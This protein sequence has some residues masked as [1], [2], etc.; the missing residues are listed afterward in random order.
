MFALAIILVGMIGI[1]AMIPFAGRQAAS[2]YNIAHGIAAGDNAVAVFNSHSI[3]SPTLNAPWQLVDDIYVSPAPPFNPTDTMGDSNLSV[4]E[5]FPKLYEGDRT[6]FRFYS[7]Y[8]YQYD[9]LEGVMPPDRNR[10]ALAQNRALGMGF[11][12]DPLF[13]GQHV[14]VPLPLNFGDPPRKLYDRDWNNLRRTRF[15]FYHESYP[16][17]MDPFASYSG[18]PL[19]NTPRLTRVSIR[20]P[21]TPL[22]TVNKGWLHLPAAIRMATSSGGDVSQISAE[23][24]RG[25]GPL[26]DFTLNQLRDANKIPMV[27]ESILQASSSLSQ[28]SWMATLT[29]S[30]STPV[31]NPLS[32]PGGVYTPPFLPPMPFYPE[33]YD[34]AVIVFAKRDVRELVIEKYSDYA[35]IGVAPSSERLARVMAFGPESRTSG[36]FDMMLN[37]DSKVNAKVRIGDWLMLSRYVYDDPTNLATTFPIRESHKWYRIISVSGEDVFPRRVRVAGAPWDWTLHELQVFKNAGFTAATVPPL[38]PTNPNTPM[39]ATL[40]TDVIN[41]FQR[42]VNVSNQ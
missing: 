21:Q 33:S 14:G 22:G 23:K 11:C 8:Q 36:T 25:R 10:A 39:V 7:L 24:D 3:T 31:V 17:S 41:V 37:S 15:P 9:L 6:N 13:W 42:T 1:A 28:Q 40:L 38:D 20:D 35:S 19:F 30:E 5:S 29:P 34:L 4:F 18:N 27:G 26:R 16:T 2:S 32:L 12:I